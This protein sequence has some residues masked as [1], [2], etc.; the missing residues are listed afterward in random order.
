MHSKNTN[1][2]CMQ[3]EA[4]LQIV[5]AMS[6]RFDPTV[7]ARPVLVSSI[8]SQHVFSRI[9]DDNLQQLLQLLEH[10]LGIVSFT[11]EERTVH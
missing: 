5:A 10:E 6:R 2:I 11:S 9:T 4:L 3:P 1:T 8:R 7:V